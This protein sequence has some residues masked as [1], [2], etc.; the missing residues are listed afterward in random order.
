MSDHE[1]GGKDLAAQQGIM[2]HRVICFCLHAV[3]PSVR[4]F[5]ERGWH[6]F[7]L[8]EFIFGW[9]PGSRVVPAVSP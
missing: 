7:I 9:L 3:H 6:G 8:C 2:F 5:W 4:H 1:T